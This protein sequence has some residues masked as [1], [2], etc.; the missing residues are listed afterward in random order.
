MPNWF[1]A[2]IATGNTLSDTRVPDISKAYW[3]WPEAAPL[4]RVLTMSRDNLRSIHDPEYKCLEQRRRGEWTQI[5]NGAGYNTT[6]DTFIVD[7]ATMFQAGDTFIVP[8]TGEQMRVQSVNYSAN[9][10]KVAERALAGT[11]TALNDD[12]WVRRIATNYSEGAAAGTTLLREADVTTNYAEIVRSTVDWTNTEL[13]SFSYLGLG[14]KSRKMHDRRNAMIQH[15]IDLEQTLLFSKKAKVTDSTTGKIFR[16]TNGLI[17]QITTNVY[18]HGAAAAMTEAQFNTNVLESV[19]KVGSRT[20]FCLASPRLCS[21]LD[22]YGR[23]G[24]QMD[25]ET[26]K[27]LGIEVKEYLSSHGRL[28]II[29]H[30]LFTG[31]LYGR[32]GLI[33]DPEYLGLAILRDTKLNTDIQNK[34]DDGVQDEWLTE[35]GLDLKLQETCAFFYGIDTGTDGGLP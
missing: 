35:L 32:A 18:N 15:T 4:G 16:K 29:P 14:K 27:V 8:R 3:L 28:K 22:G 13:A 10:I 25:S 33:F 17:A 5:N 9:T 11:A 12:D 20:K 19:F 21:L 23:A 34:K 6:A 31:Y 7:D 30:P 26:T 24:L 1:R 2:T